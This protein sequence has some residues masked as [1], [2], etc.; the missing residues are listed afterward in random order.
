MYFC[1]EEAVRSLSFVKSFI[2]RDD[3]TLSD[4]PTHCACVIC[5]VFAY[6]NDFRTTA[7]TQ[8]AIQRRRFFI[9]CEEA[10]TSAPFVFLYSTRLPWQV[11][12]AKTTFLLWIPQVVLVIEHAVREFKT[13]NLS[14]LLVLEFVFVLPKSSLSFCWGATQ[15]PDFLLPTFCS[16]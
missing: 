11:L 12:G 7:N 4:W 16:K 3:V 10:E 1:Q 5:S 6:H 14:H 15:G 8:P 2:F 9:Q 13:H